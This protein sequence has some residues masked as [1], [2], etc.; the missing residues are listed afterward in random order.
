MGSERSDLFSFTWFLALVLGGLF[1]FAALEFLARGL[2]PVLFTDGFANPEGFS[3][4]FAGAFGVAEVGP[5][6][7]F[8]ET[9]AD[10]ALELVGGLGGASFAEVPVAGEVYQIDAPMALHVL[11]G[12]FVFP[13]V[14]MLI[15][16]P[17]LFFAPWFILGPIFGAALWALWSWMGATYGQAELGA[18]Q[19]AAPFALDA[20]GQAALVAN[21]AYGL[22]LGLFARMIAGR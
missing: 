13:F 9:I 19:A 3:E 17:I 14:Y 11:A 22:V 5:S 21:L 2:T 6:L 12:V 1:A 15:F 18:E 7:R 10:A 16:R 20:I 4:I 8:N